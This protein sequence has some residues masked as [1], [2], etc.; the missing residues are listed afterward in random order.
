MCARIAYAVHLA[1][2]IASCTCHC[3]G[4]CPIERNAKVG[5]QILVRDP[6]AVVSSFG[7]VL[8][9]TLEETCYPALCSIASELRA[10][11]CA[12]ALSVSDSVQWLSGLVGSHLCAT[13]DCCRRSQQQRTA[14]NWDHFP[15]CSASVQ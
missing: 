10:R 3:P 6:M 15:E 7:E 1:C 9:A 12:G 2:T 14:S 8:E 13:R 4:C 11:G 5:L